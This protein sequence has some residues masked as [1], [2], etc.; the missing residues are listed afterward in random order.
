MNANGDGTTPPNLPASR[1]GSGAGTEKRPERAIRPKAVRRATA[2]GLPLHPER[3]TAVLTRLSGSVAC[4]HRLSE[5][6]SITLPLARLMPQ[7]M[8]S[9]GGLQLGV[10]PGLQPSFLV[11]AIGKPE[12]P[13]PQP[14]TASVPAV[15]PPVRGEADAG[16]RRRGGQAGHRGSRAHRAPRPRVMSLLAEKLCRRTGGIACFS[17]TRTGRRAQATSSALR[18]TAVMSS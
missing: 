5:L 7:S 4:A 13:G 10:R 1:K 18:M 9:A 6:L 3:A 2:G 16:R 17:P 11:Q 12:A 14:H 15:P 8:D